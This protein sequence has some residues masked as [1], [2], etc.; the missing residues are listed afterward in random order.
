[1]HVEVLVWPWPSDRIF[2]LEKTYLKHF[3]KLREVSS[4]I[5]SEFFA[6]LTSQA[7]LQ[8]KR[9]NKEHSTIKLVIIY[10][11]LKLLVLAR[12]KLDQ[13]IRALFHSLGS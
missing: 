10:V 11:T 13:A 7:T 5:S 1:M 3:A 6:F 9:E 8:S 4:D 12:R 2:N